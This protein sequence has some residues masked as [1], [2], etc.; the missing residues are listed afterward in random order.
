MHAPVC[1]TTDPKLRR[2]ESLISYLLFL[3]AQASLISRPSDVFSTLQGVQLYLPLI[4]GAMF[5]SI[6]RIHYQVSPR[7]LVQQPVN[8]CMIGLILAAGISHMQYGRVGL[9]I[10]GMIAMAKFAGYYFVAVSV[11]TTGARFRAFLIVTALASTVMVAVSIDDFHKFNDEWLGR[12]DLW[13]EFEE[14]K[15]R[16]KEDKVIRHVLES[17]GV[18]EEGDPITLTRMR[19]FGVFS[20][21][22]DIALLITVTSIISIYFLFDRRMGVFRP[23]WIGVLC[24]MGYGLWCTQSRGGLLAGGAAFMVWMLMKYGKQ[25]AIGIGLLGAMAAPVALGRLGAMNLTSGTGQER[26]RL[27]ADGLN[28]IKS[29]AI[30]FGVGENRYTEIA[31]LVAHNSYIHAFTE[32][33][34]FGGSLFFGLVFFPAYAFWKIKRHGINSDDPEVARLLPIV[35]A[36]LTGWMVGMC[37]LSRCYSPA[38]YIVVAAAT[39]YVNLAGFT[40]RVPHPVTPLTQPIV[41]RWLAA[42]C[43]LLVGAYLFVRVFV[44]YG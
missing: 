32:L 2:I 37:S 16:K 18:S 10:A 15:L 43:C 8:L 24:V 9:A 39:S 1:K 44:R 6:P 19:G 38:T 13:D 20:D 34:F 21:P 7:M 33:G 28:A 4:A 25:V 12:P 41:Q 40:Y 27:W 26:I 11:L 14:D 3:F 22:N 5:C 36:I 42:S 29:K 30:F 23:C 31:E 35:P 17:H